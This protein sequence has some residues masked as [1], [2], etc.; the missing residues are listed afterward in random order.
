MSNI[1]IFRNDFE[2]DFKSFN[3]PA[4][5]VG[6]KLNLNNT[7]FVAQTKFFA[8]SKSQTI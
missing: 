5:E 2:L 4:G 3:F 8:P 1:K 6:I 7:A